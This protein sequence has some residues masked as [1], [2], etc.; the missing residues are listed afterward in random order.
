[1]DMNLSGMFSYYDNQDPEKMTEYIKNNMIPE[2]LTDNR[3]YFYS[4]EYDFANKSTKAAYETV[5]ENGVE[6]IIYV[7]DKGEHDERAWGKKF[8]NC[9]EFFELID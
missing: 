2:I 8:E 3:V 4:G 9:L 5:K 1:M 6:N 7:S